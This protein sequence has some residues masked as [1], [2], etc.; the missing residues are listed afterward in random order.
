[1][2]RAFLRYLDAESLQRTLAMAEGWDGWSPAEL[3]RF[4]VFKFSIAA[5]A[6]PAFILSNIVEKMYAN[7][8]LVQC[9]EENPNPERFIL[10][11]ARLERGVPLVNFMAH[12]FKL[13]GGEDGFVTIFNRIIRVP[14]GTPLHCSIQ[15]ANRD[16]KYF[17]SVSLYSRQSSKSSPYYFPDQVSVFGADAEKLNFNRDPSVLGHML[18]FNG[19]ETDIS[20][21]I[22]RDDHDS[23]PRR[24]PGYGN[25][26]AIIK[27]LI[28]RYRPQSPD[29]IPKI[30]Q[31]RLAEIKSM[32]TLFQK[33][34]LKM[35][36]GR[37]IP[38]IMLLPM[39][40]DEK[41]S[42]PIPLYLGYS[43]I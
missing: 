33:F 10:E 39:T 42:Y 14:D 30:P 20:L 40:K 2:R 23:P 21:G 1:M 26:L 38:Y 19:N 13:P 18:T 27:F 15:N 16:G 37:I 4:L 43:D 24:C 36:Q 8:E 29:E 28:D 31:A 6:A 9:Y 3:V 5:G 25:A 11:M 17:D 41:D 12:D 34:V 7:P 32:E 35:G 22:A